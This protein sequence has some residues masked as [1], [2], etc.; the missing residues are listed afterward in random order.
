MQQGDGQNDLK[1][2]NAGKAS[3]IK[4]KPSGA[5]SPGRGHG[6]QS[7]CVATAPPVQLVLPP[8]IA[9]PVT[10]LGQSATPP[11]HPPVAKSAISGSMVPTTKGATL[12]G[13]QL[14]LSAGA[15]PS[16]STILS[17]PAAPLVLPGTHQVA[18]GVQRQ[19]VQLHQCYLAL[20]K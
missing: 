18:I 14:K 8:Q 20:I 17:T 13:N 3:V 6:P 15:L 12:A 10:A 5:Q 7:K 2:V 1:G 9:Q 4:T 11:H 19:Q 16:A